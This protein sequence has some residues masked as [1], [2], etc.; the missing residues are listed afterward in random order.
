MRQI[1]A[2]PDLR[3]RLG[4]RGKEMVARE[5]SPAVIAPMLRSRLA[6]IRE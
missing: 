1:A 5:L 6:L 4:A 2:S 3:Q